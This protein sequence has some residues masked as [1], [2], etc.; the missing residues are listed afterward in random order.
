MNVKHGFVRAFGMAGK[1]V[2]L[3]EVHT[4]D[5]YTGTI[6]DALV[7]LTTSL[8]CSYHFECNLEQSRREQILSTTFQKPNPIL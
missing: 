6:L 1:V 3:D 8:K 2:I 5:A 4:Y 7:E